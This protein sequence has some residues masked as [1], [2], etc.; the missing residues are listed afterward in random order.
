LSPAVAADTM[1][2]VTS[3]TAPYRP[4]AKGAIAPTQHRGRTFL[5]GWVKHCGVCGQG[6]LFRRWFWMTPRCPR[7]GLRFERVE[8]QIT[9]DIGVNTIVSFGVLLIVL[10]GGFLLTWPDPPIG[11]LIAA[12]AATA[13][14]MPLFFLP[15]SKTVWL[16]ADLMMRPLEPGEVDEGYGPQR[17]DSTPPEAPTGR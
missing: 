16:A 17:G 9:G 15:F 2:G 11:V 8:G 6:N 1:V 7:C 14:F 4:T 5:R 10:L 3:P 13:V 12:S